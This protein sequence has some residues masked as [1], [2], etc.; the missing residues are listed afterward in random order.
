MMALFY[1]FSIC[2][3]VQTLFAVWMLWAGSGNKEL[4]AESVGKP[5]SIIICAHNEAENLNKNL[6]LILQQ[7]HSDFEVIVVNDASDD[8]SA[9][10]LHELSGQYAHLLVIN[11]NKGEERLLPGK[12]FALSKG[13]ESAKNEHLLLCDADCA[14]AST[15]W[16]SLMSKRLNPPTEIVAGYGAYTKTSLWLNTFIRWETVH[17]FL[18]YSSY[19]KTGMPYMAVGRNLACTKAVLKTAQASPLWASMPSGDDDLL[20]LLEGKRNNVAIISEP[21]SFTFS[22]AKSNFGDWLKQKQRHLSTGKLYKSHIQFLLSLYGFSHGLMWLLALMLC[23]AGKAYLI[24]SMFI[25]RCMLVWCLWAITA[26]SLKERKLILWLPLCDVAWAIYNL[27][28]SPYI[29][30][31]T[32]KQW[33]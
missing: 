5:L 18:Q 12:K 1:I 13:I 30:Y 4:P 22:E 9:G 33:K 15:N 2:I 24:S 6:P 20:I 21:D 17:T 32:K 7:S 8:D 23:A 29:F 11:I 16:A 3:V 14:P 28:L 27:I 10:I 25:L 31:K 26:D 19:A